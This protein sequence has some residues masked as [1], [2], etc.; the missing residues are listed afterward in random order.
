[1]NKELEEA[2]KYL[3]KLAKEWKQ[4]GNTQQKA[5]EYLETVLNYIENSI[6]KEEFKKLQ[7]ENEMLKL[8]EKNRVLGR[9]GEIEVHELINKVL[10]EDYIATKV[11]INKI[12]ERQFELQQEY[13]D[14]KDDIKLNTLQELL[15]GK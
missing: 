5:G 6:P 14:F 8:K 1:M 4:L 15:E 9:Y 12:R 11:I 10:S 7:E 3:G 13:I 2:I